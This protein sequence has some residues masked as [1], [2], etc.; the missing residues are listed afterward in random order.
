MYCGKCGKQNTDGIRYCVHCGSDMAQQTPLPPSS[1][2]PEETVE[3]TNALRKELL[4]VSKPPTDGSRPPGAAPRKPK[5]ISADMVGVGKTLA[6][7]YKITARLGAGGMGE[8]FK[9]TDSELNDLHVAIKVLPPIL[10]GNTRSVN[11]LR[12]EAAIS[13]KLT[14]SHICR[15][16]TF[17]VDGNVKFLVM[18]YIPGNTLEE[19][20]DATDE[21]K[22][23]LA[24]ILPIARNV[25][26]ALDFAHSQ[27]PPILHRDIKPSN[28]M[29]T[30]QGVG[31]VLDFGIARELKDSMTR[32]TG[33]DTSGTL[34]YMSPEQFTGS[35]P[36]SASD[37]YSFAAMLFECLCSHAPFWQGSI[38]HQLLNQTPVRIPDM[39]DHVNDALQAGLAK[40]GGDRPATARELVRML[41]GRDKGAL[42]SSGGVLSPERPDRAAAPH[43]AAPEAAKPAAGKQ[44]AGRAGRSKPAM[45]VGRGVFISFILLVCVA[46]VGYWQD[47]WP[48]EVLTRLGL[49]PAPKSQPTTG[50]RPAPL[51]PSLASLDAA[52]KVKQEA[53]TSWEKVMNVSTENSFD[54][55]LDAVQTLLSTGEEQ[56][57]GEQYAE[58]IITYK[59]VVTRCDAIALLDAERK[60]AVAAQ[61]T[62]TKACTAAEAASAASLAAVLWQAAE[63]DSKTARKSFEA[64][65]FAD[66]TA[67]WTRAQQEYGKAAVQAL[68]TAKVNLARKQWDDAF[69]TVP[70]V[71]LEQ[72]GGTA[73]QDA[74][75]EQALAMAAGISEDA[76][77]KWHKAAT[78]LASAST[79]AVKAKKRAE[80]IA[81]HVATAQGLLKEGKYAE[82]GAAA[83][84]ALKLDPEHAGAKFLSDKADI[85]G[86]LAQ[87]RTVME[88]KPAEALAG[89][90]K[91]LST[92]KGLAAAKTADSDVKAW[93]AEA[94]AFQGLLANMYRL[95]RRLVGHG[96]AVTSLALNSDGTEMISAGVDKVVKI[97]DPTA[98]K[99]LREIDIGGEPVSVACSPD[100]AWLAWG[101]G[102]KLMIAQRA[103]Q[104]AP[105]SYE[106]HL[107]A[108][109]AV[110]FSPS[111]KTIVTCG[112]DN[113]LIIR[114]VA[115]GKV[116]TTLD[117]T[118]DVTCLAFSADGKVLVSGSGKIIVGG[119]DKLVKIWDLVGGKVLHELGGHAKMIRAVAFSQDGKWVASGG[120]DGLILVHDAHTG[121]E[122]ARLTGHKGT[123]S[124]LSFRKDALRLASA[125]ADK[126]VHLWD[127]ATG[128]C[129]QTLEG[130][131]GWVRV[132][133][134][135][136]DGKRL[137]TA[138]DDT[139]II[140][141]V[142]GLEA[143][144]SAEAPSGS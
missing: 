53:K 34:L 7:R 12:T 31:K 111:G 127:P 32:M 98:E 48:Q 44:K 97:W 94:E 66:A 13:L 80:Q 104:A 95:E 43:Q 109:L 64:C 110:A 79:E 143:A 39:P 144:P 139:R 54:L 17:R 105:V 136:S 108:I 106:G 107:L 19:M 126:K 59:K 142:M 65:K 57:K 133:Q 55:K 42:E 35:T 16:H 38:A 101:V 25:A 82:A 8:V 91:L 84:E 29:V 115:T 14:H 40:N 103:G 83:A 24:K 67:A 73:W 63:A 45:R 69:G 123:V 3:D 96:K 119:D 122:V 11:R 15:L 120:D 75:A 112:E 52:T 76:A 134:F 27:N 131:T 116:V 50:T 87:A 81:A 78:L 92:L 36:T 68:L 49:A 1:T 124:S 141:W 114:D 128:K 140:I 138:G 28:V 121:K 37:I 26:D 46:G 6:G 18:E 86:Q 72:Y 135:S 5:V 113:K 100:G 93:L 137:I 56:M 9:A 30:P 33:K 60:T 58:A 90:R 74:R 129:T 118:D 41:E 22:L 47:W 132:V 99:V 130:H 21:R 102:A 51:Q 71:L 2:P 117:N 88:S 85:G 77:A 70:Q 20:L 4:D 125:G 23:P 61:V 89:V 10:A 62:V